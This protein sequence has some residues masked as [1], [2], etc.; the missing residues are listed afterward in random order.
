MKSDKLKQLATD[1]KQYCDERHTSCKECPGN[2]P[3]AEFNDNSLCDISQ[4]SD[5]R[6]Q[7]VPDIMEAVKNRGNDD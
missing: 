6:S 2:N 7:E 4:H 3:I 5:N 1:M